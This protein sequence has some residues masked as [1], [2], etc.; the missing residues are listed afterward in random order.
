MAP[1]DATGD[2]QNQKAVIV[3]DVTEVWRPDVDMYCTHDSETAPG[4]RCVRGWK[5]HDGIVLILSTPLGRFA[6]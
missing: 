6:N 3:D 2:A 4:G 1:D 5:R